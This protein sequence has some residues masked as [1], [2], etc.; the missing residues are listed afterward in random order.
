MVSFDS[1]SGVTGH[2]VYYLTNLE[3]ARRDVP[4]KWVREYSFAEEWQTQGQ[5]PDVKTMQTIYDRIRDDPQARA[6][7]LKLL[8]TSSTHDPTPASGVRRLFC[9]IA[10]LDPAAYQACACSTPAP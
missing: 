6:Q 4:G 2:S 5:A 10:D 7:W 3:A 9:A 1:S 8:N